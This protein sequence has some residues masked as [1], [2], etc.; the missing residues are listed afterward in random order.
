MT[1]GVVAMPPNVRSTRMLSLCAELADELAVSLADEA[2]YQ[3]IHIRSNIGLVSGD[4]LRAQVRVDR[5][6]PSRVPRRIAFLRHQQR[7]AFRSVRLVALRTGEGLP[8]L[9]DAAHVFIAADPPV[10]GSDI[11]A[12]HRTVIQMSLQRL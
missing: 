4:H 6:A 2:V 10:P 5:T 1:K 7:Q 12:R 9:A 8:V 3:G 11:T